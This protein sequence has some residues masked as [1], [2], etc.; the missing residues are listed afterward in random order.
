MAIELGILRVE[1]FRQLLRD[2]T[3]SAGGIESEYTPENARVRPEIHTGMVVKAMI[4]REQE[5]VHEV[6]RQL[7]VGDLT[8]IE[9]KIAAKRNIVGR[10]QFG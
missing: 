5:R 3:A 1:I 10:N 4:F 2:S 9:P 6:R 7:I 8:A